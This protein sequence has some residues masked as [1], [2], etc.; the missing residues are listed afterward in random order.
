MLD[1]CSEW[2]I[3]RF[4]ALQANL[5]T[6]FFLMGGSDFFGFAVSFLA[7]CHSPTAP[8]Y[9]MPHSHPQQAHSFDVSRPNLS[10]SVGLHP[11]RYS[12]TEALRG[13]IK[14]PPSP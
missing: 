11:R 10:Y 8:W 1:I 13:W 3:Y 9:T 7:F 4:H 14:P 5:K 2:V 6:D 12:A